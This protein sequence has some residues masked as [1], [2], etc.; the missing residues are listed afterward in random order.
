MSMGA[1]PGSPSETMR[2]GWPSSS[3]T[4]SPTLRSLTGRPA[5]SDA[6]TGT[7]T[8][9]ELSRRTSSWSCVGF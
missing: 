6:E 3:I 9:R 5:A 4:K 7:I 2:C 8:S 1:F